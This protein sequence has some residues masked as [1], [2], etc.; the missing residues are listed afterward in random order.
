MSGDFQTSNLKA[1]LNNQHTLKNIIFI[2]SHIYTMLSSLTLRFFGRTLSNVK[3]NAM[4]GYDCSNN[5]MTYSC[6][7]WPENLRDV[8][9]DLDGR[10][11]DSDLHAAQVHKIYHLLHKIHV[12]PS[13]R[14]AKMGCTIDTIT[15]SAQ[16]KKLAD[17]K[18]AVIVYLLDYCN[19]PPS[20]EKEFNAFISI[21]MV[22]AV[23]IRHLPQYFKHS[24]TVITA[25]TQ[26]ESCYTEYQSTD[27][28]R[29]YQWP[30]S[31]CPS[32]MSFMVTAQT[33]T[34][35]ALVLESNIKGMGIE[36]PE[37]LDEKTIAEHLQEQLQLSDQRG[38]E[39]FKC[40][41]E[42]MYVYA[43]VGYARAYMSMHYFTFVRPGA[44][45]DEGNDDSC[46]QTEWHH[47]VSSQRRD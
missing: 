40:K 33:T 22:E 2:Y 43:E 5:E 37:E 13:H 9:G 38:L 1:I 42:Y 27:Y 12:R 6:A 23:E 18:I 30:N 14:V 35:R 11:N 17:K 45:D 20:F 26:L 44:L 34:S 24:V 25:T 16:Q 46:S 29:R 8:H 7:L 3:L 15:L 10:S 47:E 21:E 39:M 19:L 41:W 4:T 36:T 32:V 31:F 28:A